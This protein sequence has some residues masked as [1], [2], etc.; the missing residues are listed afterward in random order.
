M[1]VFSQRMGNDIN[2]FGRRLNNQSRT[3]G[4]RF[5]FTRINN[6]LHTF[7]EFANPALKFATLTNPELAPFTAV[8]GAGL[9]MAEQGTKYAARFAD[10]HHQH[11]Q[12]RPRLER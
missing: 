8:L 12:H 2:T 10:D 3:F 4:Q 11:K 1:T 5:N 7:N 9:N 6:G